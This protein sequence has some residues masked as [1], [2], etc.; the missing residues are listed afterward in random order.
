MKIFDSTKPKF[1][2]LFQAT[3]SPHHLPSSLSMYF[4]YKVIGNQNLDPIAQGWVGDIRYKWM[5]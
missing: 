5:N 1:S 3:C 4:T 2:H